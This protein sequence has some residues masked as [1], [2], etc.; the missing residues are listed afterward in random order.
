ME[1]VC[2]KHVG[3][4]KGEYGLVGNHKGKRLHGRSRR[5]RENNINLLA[6][7]FFFQILAHS[8]FKM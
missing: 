8:V 4:D 5:R 1:G 7:D 3:E 2:G 6:T